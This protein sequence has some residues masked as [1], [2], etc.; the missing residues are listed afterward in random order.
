MK[1]IIC[2]LICAALILSCGSTAFASEKKS[3]NPTILISGFLCSQLYLDYGTDNEKSIWKSV[4]ERAADY[5]GSNITGTAKS[6]AKLIM[7]KTD[8]FGK[9]L[10]KGAEYILDVFRCNA[11]GSSAYNLKH[12]PNNPETSNLEYMYKNGLEQRL[13]EKN[14][15]RYLSEQTDPGRVYCFQY[16]SRL[17]AITVAKE[18]RDFINAVKEYNNSEKVNIFALSFGGLIT[19]TYLTLYENENS[20]EKVV[21]SV[22]A[23]G[24]TNIPDRLFRGTIALP[25]EDIVMFFETVFEGEANL[26]R[27]FEGDETDS[28]NRILSSSAYGFRNALLHWGSIWSLCSADLYENLKN[29]Y[30]DPEKNAAIIKNNDL[31]HYEIKPQFKSVYNRLIEKGGSVSIICATGSGLV[32]GGNYNG[33]VILPAEKVSGAACAPAGKRF[34]DGYEGKKTSCSDSS[35]NH[36]SPSREI[37]ATCA[38]LPE[39]TWFVEGQYHGQYF[40]EEYTR[41]LVTKLLFTDEIKDVHSSKAFPQFE[42]SNN[43]YKNLHAGFDA[44]PSGY[45]TTDDSRL[46]IKNLSEENYIRLLAVKTYGADLDFDISGSGILEPGEEISLSFEGIIPEKSGTAAQITISYAEI[47]SLN[48][49]NISDFSITVNNGAFPAY[50]NTLTSS[51]FVTDFRN[52]VSDSFYNLLSRLSLRQSIECIYNSITELI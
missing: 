45:L 23:I 19:S 3:D 20:V 34:S 47:G 44:S 1:R 2:L 4:A 38:Y 42:Y 48:L 13:Y 14:F 49:L 21:M 16:D 28:L 9:E 30:L 36:I 31:L 22:P 11:D 26:A 33:D 18:L 39:N 41:S 40:Y 24:G 46:I 15:C 51:E 32:A 35:H 8:D 27:I 37:D 50:E 25:A 17:D 10:G 29:D 12:Y 43:R 5:F 6:V 52:A 7:G